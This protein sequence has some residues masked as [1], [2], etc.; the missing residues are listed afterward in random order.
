MVKIA[1]HVR[2]DEGVNDLPPD[3]VPPNVVN[4]QHAQNGEP[5]PA[6]VEETS[7]NQFTFHLNPFSY[8]MMKGVQVTDDNPS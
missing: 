4:L 2:F 8:T 5:L 6:K 7:V 3:L 1:K